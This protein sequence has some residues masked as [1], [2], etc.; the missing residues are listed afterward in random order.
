MK[1]AASNANETN[2]MSKKNERRL[3]SVTS[4]DKSLRGTKCECSKIQECSVTIAWEQG[5]QY[6]AALGCGL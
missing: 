5:L 3:P 4:T 6:S 2:E 1:N